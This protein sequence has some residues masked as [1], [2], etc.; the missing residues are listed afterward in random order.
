MLDVGF[1]DERAINE[2]SVARSTSEDSAALKPGDYSRNGRL[3]QLPLGVKL[4]P[5]LRDGQLALFP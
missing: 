3:S 1:G 2:L 4:L 5:D